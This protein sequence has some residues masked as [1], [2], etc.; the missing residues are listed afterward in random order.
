[1][2]EP[3]GILQPGKGRIDGDYYLPSTPDDVR[4]GYVPGIG[5]D[6]VL[7]VP[8]GS[9]VTIDTVSHE[10]IL[11]DQDQGRDPV[12]W[13]AERGVARRQVLDDAVEIA[14]D[15]DRTPRS[16]DLD[17]P[18][19][20]TGPVFVS[21]A[22]PGDVLK[23][24]TLS[25][26]PH[27]PYGVVSSRHGKGALPRTAAGGAPDGITLEEVMP[28]VGTDGR[29][30][31][32]QPEDYGNVSVFTPVQ[33][34]RGIPSGVMPVGTGGEVSFPIDPFM[35]LMGVASAVSEVWWTRC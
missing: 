27:V 17:G 21:G 9:T 24:E 26:V 16:F 28:P 31:G 25:A 33:R 12:A 19:V 23:V 34:R 2:E 7:T 30:T 22:R 15:Y 3:R 5:A 20:V 32:V 8:S 18:H 13:F 11:E 14:R 10:G 35:G 4:W 6:P 1:M 29:G